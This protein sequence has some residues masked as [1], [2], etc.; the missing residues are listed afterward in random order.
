MTNKS[1]RSL[2]AKKLNALLAGEVFADDKTILK[3]S[4]DQSIYE[5]KSLTANG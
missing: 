2:I 4:R 1:E 5:V 3:F